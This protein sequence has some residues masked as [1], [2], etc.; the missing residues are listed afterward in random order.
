MI[1]ILEALIRR[2]RGH[3]VAKGRHSESGEGEKEGDRLGGGAAASQEVGLIFVTTHYPML[4]LADEGGG[5]RWS[6]FEEAIRP[7]K[8]K[9]TSE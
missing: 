2:S 7:G 4:L 9:A 8:K 6:F 3:V 5:W 1:G